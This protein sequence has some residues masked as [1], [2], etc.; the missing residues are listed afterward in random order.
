MK[1]TEMA[2]LPWGKRREAL[3]RAEEML[4]DCCRHLA[5]P[6]KGFGKSGRD[7]I[8]R[9]RWDGDLSEMRR[10]ICGAALAAEG[11]S[12]ESSHFP[13]RRIRD[14]EAFAKVLFD[15]LSLEEAAR[16]KI[17][18]FFARLGEVEARGVHRLV[19]RQVERPLIEECLRWA[20]GNQLKAARVLGINRNTLRKKMREFKVAA[21]D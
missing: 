14:H 18:H 9:R 10:V 2:F 6:R 12:V 5:L 4:E 16:H 19:V 20:G 8:A 13:P 1:I 21:K 7:W 17:S 3:K 15:G 11:P